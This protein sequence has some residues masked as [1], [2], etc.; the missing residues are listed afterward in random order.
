[1]DIL[2]IVIEVLALICTGTM[3]GNEFAVGAFVHPKLCQL[4]DHTHTRSAKVLAQTYGHVMPAWYAI[5]LVLNIAVVLT[6]PTSW[7][8]PWLLACISAVFFAVTIGFTII[9][10]V[11]INNRVSAWDLDEL[12]SNW[13]EQRQR[14]DR[15]HVV[16]VIILLVA[17]TLLILS[18]VLGH[19]V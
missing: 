11:P 5:T 14:W 12:P 4:D 13:Q 17:F 7:S 6:I 15:L 1:M 2:K 9:L 16:R 8:V 3:V 18:V 19:A 10:M